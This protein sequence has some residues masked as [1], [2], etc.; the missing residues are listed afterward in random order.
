MKKLQKAQDNGKDQ[1]E[2]EQKW[3]YCMRQDQ[4][5]RTP[6]ELDLNSKEVV[7]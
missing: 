4:D 1:G 5:G 6:A 7:C 3:N 2:M